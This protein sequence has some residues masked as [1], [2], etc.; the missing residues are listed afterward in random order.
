M[1]VTLRAESYANVHP[2]LE[3]MGLPG[4]WE[5]D[6][7]N[8]SYGRESD[9]HQSITIEDGKVSNVEDSTTVLSNL[10]NRVSKHT[11]VVRGLS[12]IE[13]DSIEIVEE[14]LAAINTDESVRFG[15]AHPSIQGPAGETMLGYM[16]SAGNQLYP[17]GGMLLHSAT[18]TKGAQLSI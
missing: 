11:Y 3:K 10:N 4:V 13:A 7:R 6:V 14:M 9:R 8:A 2:I 12:D 1:D 5:I 16:L 17:P 15:V 18:F